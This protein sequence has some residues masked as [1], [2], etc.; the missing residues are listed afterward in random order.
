MRLDS[1]LR[2]LLGLATAGMLAG[3]GA[4]FLWVPTE[5]FNG[6]VQRLMY[7]HVPAAWIAYL[8]F[9]VVL[10]GS[11]AYLRSGARRWDALAHAGAETG[12]LFAAI[13]LATGMLW[14]RPIWGA[15]WVWDA[16]L[17]SM[18]V[19]ALIY[20]GYLAFRSMATDATQ[21]ARV[22]AVIGI[23]GFVD[24][25]LVHF[26]VFWWRS[27]HPSRTVIGGPNL[28]GEMLATVLIMAGIFTVVFALL[29]VLRVRL[30]RLQD[31]V[32]LLETGAL[33]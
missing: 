24:V 25:P 13:N 31:E 23:V 10:V 18:F 29:L 14:A 6:V 12:L 5:E 22:A 1:S 21:G 7:V 19:L 16:R 26:S 30:L 9:A 28:P 2:T 15:Y 8:A 33:P 17:T 20:L 3:L 32:A 27:Q 11:V 4:I